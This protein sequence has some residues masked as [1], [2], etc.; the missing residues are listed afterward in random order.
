MRPL[1][2]F[3]LRLFR[4]RLFIRDRPSRFNPRRRQ[5][6]LFSPSVMEA[7]FLLVALLFGRFATTVD[8]QCE[9]STRLLYLPRSCVCYVGR[10]MTSKGGW[11]CIH[12]YIVTLY[13]SF[14]KLFVICGLTIIY[15][16]MWCCFAGV[17]VWILLAV[18]YK[19]PF[20]MACY[21]YVPCFHKTESKVLLFWAT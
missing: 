7:L 21:K 6:V 14:F 8:C 11:M 3:R 15:N 10:Y 2:L 12:F 1:R 16:S 20:F 4:L 13:Y 19:Y 9:L 5:P 18:L 17:C